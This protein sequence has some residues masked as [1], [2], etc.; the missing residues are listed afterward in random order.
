MFSLVIGNVNAKDGSCPPPVLQTFASV[1]L[2]G[3]AE[4]G[5]VHALMTGNPFF[6][7]SNSCGVKATFPTQREMEI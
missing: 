1:P 7:F 4:S 5:R 2:S 6:D 3:S